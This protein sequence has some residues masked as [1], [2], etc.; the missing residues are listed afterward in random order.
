MPILSLKG[1]ETRWYDLVRK[2]FSNVY[3]WN[4]SIFG[5]SSVHYVGRGWPPFGVPEEGSGTGGGHNYVNI[6]RVEYG[7]EYLIKEYK[8]Q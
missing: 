4:E 6:D 3:T 7:S 2:H 5:L 8:C 1:K